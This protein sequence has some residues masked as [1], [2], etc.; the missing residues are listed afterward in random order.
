MVET[1]HPLASGN[2]GGVLHQLLATSSRT[3][4]SPVSGSGRYAVVSRLSC[5]VETVKPVSIIPSGSK[6]RSR[7]TDSRSWPHA[8]ARRTPSTW[9]DVL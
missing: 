6:M 8:R 2:E 9:P 3:D 4:S 5:S 7:S 1:S